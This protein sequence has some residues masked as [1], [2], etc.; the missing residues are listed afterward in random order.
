MICLWVNKT[1]SW[2]YSANEMPLWS[3]YLSH[4][5]KKWCICILTNR[6]KRAMDFHKLKLRERK[7]RRCKKNRYSTRE[8]AVAVIMGTRLAT[9]LTI[10]PTINKWL[11]WCRTTRVRSA[12]RRTVVQGW[13]ASQ[14][15]VE[16]RSCPKPTRNHLT[17][18]EQ[19]KMTFIFECF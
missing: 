17:L 19:V 4:L 1:L 15:E 6:G 7:W 3:Q 16:A 8:G 13:E 10:T 12:R 18:R 2:A 9:Q 14:S 11:W 5:S